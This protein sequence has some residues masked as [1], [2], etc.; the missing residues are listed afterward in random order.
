MSGGG[1]ARSYHT[2][3]SPADD[4]GAGGAASLFL[5]LTERAVRRARL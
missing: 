5:N 3:Q 1:R 4:R 2:A